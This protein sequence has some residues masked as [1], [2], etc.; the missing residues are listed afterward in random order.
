MRPTPHPTPMG[1]L[2]TPTNRQVY[3]KTPLSPTNKQ[4]S[5]CIVRPRLSPGYKKQTG[6]CPL[7]WQRLS[8]LT[9]SSFFSLPRYEP[10]KFFFQPAHMDFDQGQQADWLWLLCPELAGQTQ[11]RVDGCE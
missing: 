8:L 4:V 7:H 5:R 9:I 6:S 10:G 11:G 3:P 1:A 2:Y